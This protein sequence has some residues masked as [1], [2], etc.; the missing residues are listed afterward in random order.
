L[1]TSDN[2]RLASALMSDQS[3]FGVELDDE[4]ITVRTAQFAAFTSAIPPVAKRE[5]VSIFELRPTDESLES[6]F[7]YLVKR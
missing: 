5:G 2:R 3:V 7:S 1:R 6:V 4:R